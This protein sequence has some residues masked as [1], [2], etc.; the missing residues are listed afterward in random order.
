MT[1]EQLYTE[2][3]AALAVFSKQT[4]HPSNCILFIKAPRGVDEITVHIDGCGILAFTL[5]NYPNYN[6]VTLENYCDLSLCRKAV[7]MIVARI[8]QNDKEVSFD[9]EALDSRC[10]R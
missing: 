8:R 2:V 6:R 7:N 1:T 5:C 9:C 3:Q 4:K 10:R